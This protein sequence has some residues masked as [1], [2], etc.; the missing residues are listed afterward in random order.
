MSDLT[1]AVQAD[2]LGSYV[3]LRGGFPIP[4]AGATYWGVLAY[5]GWRYDF[6]AWLAVAMWGSGMIFPLAL[7]L[8]RLFKVNFMGDRTS[9]SSVL[10]PTFMSMFL[11]WPMLIAAVGVAPALAPLILAIG[12]SLHWPVIG[13]SY[14]RTGLYTAHAVVR[15]IAVFAIWAMLPDARLTLLPLSVCVVYLG[16]VAAILIDLGR[17]QRRAAPALASS[18]A[19]L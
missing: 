8:A 11:F 4:L 19:T 1:A 5:V 13:W 12:M 17:M 7:L 6:K 18:A 2:R 3:R 15:A 10:L 14:G 9:V 16:T